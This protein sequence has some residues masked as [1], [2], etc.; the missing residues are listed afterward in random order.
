MT[1]YAAHSRI[2]LS[3]SD[4]SPCPSRLKLR[5]PPSWVTSTRL[6]STTAPAGQSDNGERGL[7]KQIP[8]R[9]NPIT[10][11]SAF[12]I[13]AAAPPNNPV[14]SQ[15]ARPM[16]LSR[17]PEPDIFKAIATASFA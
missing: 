9:S 10:S 7:R 1:F 14:K 8:K 13:G 4:I 16:A 12:D 11:E 15:T 17:A 5:T 2:A 3:L 6:R